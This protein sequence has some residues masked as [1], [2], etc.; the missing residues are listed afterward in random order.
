MS[1][2]HAGEGA[3]KIKPGQRPCR[4]LGTL[5]DSDLGRGFRIAFL[6][7]FHLTKG[8]DQMRLLSADQMVGVCI[9]VLFCK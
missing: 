9:I 4:R 5:S 2:A 1:L 7:L 6:P 3:W 8:K